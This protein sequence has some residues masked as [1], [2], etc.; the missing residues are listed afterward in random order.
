MLIPAP[1]LRSV[2]PPGQFSRRI[3]QKHHDLA[4]LQSKPQEYTHN[5]QWPRLEV[6]SSYR[7]TNER[8]YVFGNNEQGVPWRSLED[9]PTDKAGWRRLKRQDLSSAPEQSS[10]AVPRPTVALNLYRALLRQTS[11]LPDPLSRTY[12]KAHIRSRFRD[13]QH[14]RKHR[15][16]VIVSPGAKYQESP[17]QVIS[18]QSSRDAK[19]GK[20]RIV[21]LLAQARQE[22]RFLE[23]ANKGHPG[24]LQK[25]LDLTYGR[26][27]K[28]KHVLLRDLALP[29]PQPMTSEE[30][31]ELARAIQAEAEA[32]K[33]PGTPKLALVSD[34]FTALV[35]SQMHQKDEIFNKPPLKSIEPKLPKTNS[36]G[37]SLPLK[38]KNNLIKKWY[39]QTL[40]RLMPPLPEKEWKQLGDLAS[41]KAAWHGPPKRRA[42]GKEIF[43]H[44][45]FIANFV[46]SSRRLHGLAVEQL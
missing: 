14:F 16:G 45:P 18:W 9:L 35:K 38:R 1:V 4:G 22:L 21:Q 36:W 5:G 12:F 33:P 20:K 30:L 10:Q 15:P 3:S 19:S 41:G 25:V 42:R 11:Y 2:K 46:V 39:A 26:R 23:T 31:E 17:G 27:G 24:H 34:K 43:E 44:T 8:R 6:E 29:K 13:N 28:R 32:N 7:Q 37:R 40:D